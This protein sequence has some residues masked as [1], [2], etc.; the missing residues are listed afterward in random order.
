M[1]TGCKGADGFTVFKVSGSAEAAIEEQS[2]SRESSASSR[3]NWLLKKSDPNSKND[4]GKH[5]GH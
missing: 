4:L 3:K 1:Q 2:K 5:K